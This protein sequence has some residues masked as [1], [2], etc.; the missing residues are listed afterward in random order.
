MFG[1]QASVV[2]IAIRNDWVAPENGAFKSLTQS[3]LQPRSIPAAEKRLVATGLS[4][5][6]R[7]NGL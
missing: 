3:S 2:S 5:A 6:A 7:Y 1:Q 4:T